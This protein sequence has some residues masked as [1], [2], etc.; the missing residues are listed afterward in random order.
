MKKIGILT[1]HDALNFGAVLQSYA[2]QT[3]LSQ[4][5][6]YDVRIIDYKP[7]YRKSFAPQKFTSRNPIKILLSKILELYYF[8]SLNT[9][10]HRFIDFSANCQRL[11]NKKY[12]TI[13]DFE[14]YSSE[15][16]ILISGS[17]QVFN[18]KQD[19]QIYYLG[20]NVANCVR[21]AYAP[22]L[23]LS[24]LSAEAEAMITPW[25]K[26]FDAL[27][28]RED[29]GANVLSKISG[30]KVQVV[31]DPV[32]LLT[33]KDWMKLS[34]QPKDHNFIFVY[35][36]NGGERLFQLA[37]KLSKQTGLPIIYSA[38]KVIHPYVKNCEIRHD[39]G[40]KEWLGYITKASYVVTDSFHGTMLS[41]MLET[42]VITNI[43]VKSTSSRITSIMARLGIQ[44]QLIDNI[45]EFD[46]ERIKFNPYQN[47]LKNFISESQEYLISAIQTT[48]SK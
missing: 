23:G 17:D 44:E 22:S 12:F 38:L 34:V 6:G 32:C 13:K 46:I 8:H 4:Q 39:L 21:I 11:T 5:N 45:E 47:I 10:N 25:V 40:P 29:D 41:L 18:P 20:F 42:P 14:N 19:S 15:Y 43:A 48:R 37:T 9:R 2:L 33:K 36:L 28:C 16:D 24:S 30:A 26:Q 1:F 27:S 3:Y 31:C 7:S 35:D